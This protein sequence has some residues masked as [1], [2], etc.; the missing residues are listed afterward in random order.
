M[1]VLSPGR[2]PEATPLTTSVDLS[3]PDGPLIRVVGELAYATCAPLRDEVD[4]VL[5][6]APPTLVLDFGDLHF[7]DSTGLAVIVHAWREGRHVGT[8]VRLRAVPAFLASILD[9]TGVAG[10]LTRPAQARPGEQR[11]A[12]TG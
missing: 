12:A 3:D 9:I 11:P 6:D 10:L 8:T 4:R 7:I 5:A 1:N 2:R